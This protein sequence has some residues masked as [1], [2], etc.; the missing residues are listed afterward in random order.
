MI[1][2]EILDLNQVKVNLQI[3]VSRKVEVNQKEI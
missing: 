3:E 1:Y 2:K